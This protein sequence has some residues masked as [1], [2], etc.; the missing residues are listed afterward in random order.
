[1]NRRLGMGLLG[2]LGIGGIALW[3]AA[4][5]CQGDEGDVNGDGVIDQAD[6]DMIAAS[7]LDP[8]ANPLTPEQFRRADVDGN[9]VVDVYDISLIAR[10]IAGEIDKFPKCK[11]FWQR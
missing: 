5:R 4:P 1:M 3:L 6:L 7:I 9:G 2:V 8:V 10:Y 11:W